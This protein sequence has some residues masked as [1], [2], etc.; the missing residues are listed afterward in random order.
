MSE[1]VGTD[2]P[3]RC[4]LYSEECPEGQI[5]DGEDV[6]AALEGDWEPQ[7]PDSAGDPPV[8]EAAAQ[9]ANDL[10]A[11]QAEIDQLNEVCA[12]LL[13][14]QHGLKA[15]IEGHGQVVL[16]LETKI[17]ALEFELD[18]QAQADVEEAEG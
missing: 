14:E 10:A 1:E 11:A 4:W 3:G 13:A 17:K 12:S 9:A 8:E 15:Q 5:F 16:D 18:E 6:E 7:P 2:A